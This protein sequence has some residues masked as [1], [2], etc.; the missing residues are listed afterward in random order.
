MI[1]M[2]A[3]VY[4]YVMYVCLVSLQTFNIH[5]AIA[6]GKTLERFY[7]LWH[8]LK[9]I[10]FLMSYKIVGENKFLNSYECINSTIQLLCFLTCLLTTFTLSLYCAW[11]ELVIFFTLFATLYVLSLYDSLYHPNCL[12]VLSSAL[13]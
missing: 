1:N 6:W 4:R 11:S 8:F 10:K 7:F 5:E 2:I 13:L 3:V 12:G 9:L